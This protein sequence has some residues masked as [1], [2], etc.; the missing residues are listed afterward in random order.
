MTCL[1]MGVFSCFVWEK[2][3]CLEFWLFGLV[4]CSS[5]C[6]TPK[7]QGEPDIRFSSKIFRIRVSFQ[8]IYCVC[9]CICLGILAHLPHIEDMVGQCQGL[10]QVQGQGAGQGT[11]LLPSCFSFFF[12]YYELGLLSWIYDWFILMC[13]K[14]LTGVVNQVRL[15]IQE[16]T[17]MLQDCQ[18]GS[19]SGN[20]RSI[21]QVRDRYAKPYFNC[22]NQYLVHLLCCDSIMLVNVYQ[23]LHGGGAS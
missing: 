20:L 14:W 16:T 4:W 6:H 7:D 17:C 5:R 22:C 8:S 10:C 11:C 19:P 9:C 3:Y 21:S 23:F 18:L 13:F 15:R 1:W 2:C 12:F